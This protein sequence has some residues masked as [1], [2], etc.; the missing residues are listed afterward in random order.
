MG[1]EHKVVVVQPDLFV[2]FLGIVCFETAGR[3]QALL[4][5]LG[6]YLVEFGYLGL[7]G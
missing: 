4:G 7:F 3:E 6:F 2:V 5:E 1:L